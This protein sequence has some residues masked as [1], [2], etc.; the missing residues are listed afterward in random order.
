MT[1][2]IVGVLVAV[3]VGLVVRDARR[4]V[5][6]KQTGPGAGGGGDA[7]SRTPVDKV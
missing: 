3:I 2:I 5:G 1:Y 7:R 6:N 4:K